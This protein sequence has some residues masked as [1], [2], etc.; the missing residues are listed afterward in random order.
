MPEFGI[1]ITAFA[2]VPEVAQGYVK[3][4]RPRWALEEAGLPYSVRLIGPEEN[5]GAEYRQWQPFGQVPAYR[6]REMKIFETGAILLRIA[7]LSENLRAWDEAERGQQMAWVTAALNSVEPMVNNTVHPGIFHAGEDWVEGFQPA[8]DRLT[9]M[10]LDSLSGWLDGKDWLTGRFSVADIVM[11]T[12]LRALENRPL[13]T[14]RPVLSAYLKRCLDRPA[15]AR[16]LD[17]QL[18]DFAR[19]EAA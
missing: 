18:A 17:G 5:N 11:A 7:E 12:V 8:A 9:A 13:L 3:D 1:E 10:R 19:Y 4:L 2:W 14:E 16:A 15:F 6:D